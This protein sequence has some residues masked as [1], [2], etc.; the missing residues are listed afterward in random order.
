MAL[1]CTSTP[2][3]E[4]N[5]NI[6]NESVPCPLVPAETAPVG[7]CQI[8]DQ[9]V[10]VPTTQATDIADQDAECKGIVEDSVREGREVGSCLLP[11]STIM[12]FDDQCTAAN[13]IVKEFATESRN[14]SDTGQPDSSRGRSR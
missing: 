4:G 14:M 1:R 11:R 10:K 13:V 6:A 8:K 7:P 12:Q 5:G 3:P 9:R 2:G